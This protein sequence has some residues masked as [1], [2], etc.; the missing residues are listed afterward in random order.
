MGM[1]QRLKDQGGTGVHNPLRDT[2]YSLGAGDPFYR[3]TDANLEKMPTYEEMKKRHGTLS[4]SK[5]DEIMKAR[6]YVPK[7]YMSNLIGKN[8]THGANILSNTYIKAKAGAN[9]NAEKVDLGEMERRNRMR[10]GVKKPANIWRHE[11]DDTRITAEQI[12]CN[13][14]KANM[15]DAEAARTNI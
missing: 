3:R 4:K 13:D 15:F 14:F 11:M 6:P 12:R 2:G 9:E 10:Y 8:D 5:Y 1:A 7:N